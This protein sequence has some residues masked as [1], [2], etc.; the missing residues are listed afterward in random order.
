VIRIP[1]TVLLL[2]GAAA[3]FACARA[4]PPPGGEQDRLPPGLVS[5]AP[6]PLEVVPGFKGPVVFRFDERISERGFS[7]ALVTV[8]PLDSTMRV[9]RA[10]NE[11]RVEIDGGW[12]PDRIYRVVLLPG[13]RDLFG[14]ER[15]EPTEVVFSTG[16]PVPNTAIG[17]IVLD[18]LTN[19]VVQRP[20]VRAVR[21]GE[22]VAYTAVGDT[23]GFFSLRHMP[24]GV[25]DIV[26]FADANRNRRHDPA[27][28][29][30]SAQASLASQADT[31]TFVF[32][33]LAPDSTPPRVTRAESVDSL[34]VR[35]TFDDHFDPAATMTAAVVQLHALPDSALVP[36]AARIMVATVFE[37]ERRGAPAAAPADTAAADTAAA[38]RPAAPAQLPRPAGR[39][40]APAAPPL[41]SR[42]LV[43]ELDQPLPPGTYAITI[44]GVVN[45]SGLAGGGTARFEIAAPRVAPEPP[46]AA[47]PDSTRRR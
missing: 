5:T 37:Q 10:R 8:S 44:S 20:V 15:D 45:I 34:R 1:V 32:N 14:N 12:R 27:E 11:I 39:A 35:V 30:D 31:L 3:L 13:I 17:G 33:V 18:R 28:P 22:N 25:Y 26:A 7:E 24:M 21:R 16:P 6:A 43:V 4:Y 9:Q 46:P 40:A 36:A 23:A 29:L 19:R 2:A 38:V 47:P 41:P 42:D